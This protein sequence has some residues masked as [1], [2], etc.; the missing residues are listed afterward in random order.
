MF[1]QIES[2]KESTNITGKKDNNLLSQMFGIDTNEIGDWIQD[3]LD[4]YPDLDWSISVYTNQK[5]FINLFSEDRIHPKDYPISNE[6]IEFLDD[7]LREHQCCLVTYHDEKQGGT[8]IGQDY[9]RYRT[10]EIVFK[11]VTFD[12]LVLCNH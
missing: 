7:R 6:Q 5:F 8:L 9:I 11:I 3:I 4:D 10:D 1:K 12:Y 2:I